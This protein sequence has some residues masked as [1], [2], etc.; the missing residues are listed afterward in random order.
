[1]RPEETGDLLLTSFERAI[2]QIANSA[3]CNV[4][5]SVPIGK[6]RGDQTR[7]DI[8]RYFGH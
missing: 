1:V 8:L 6:W 4:G 2:S 7:Q 5:L 3:E